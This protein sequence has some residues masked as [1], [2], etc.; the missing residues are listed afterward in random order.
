MSGGGSTIHTAEFLTA[1]AGPKI[2]TP[3]SS[4]TNSHSQSRR[5]EF[6]TIL[7]IPGISGGFFNIVPLGVIAIGSFLV[8]AVTVLKHPFCVDL[9]DYKDKFDGYKRA[10]ARVGTVIVVITIAVSLPLNYIQQTKPTGFM[11]LNSFGPLE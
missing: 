11:I 3:T 7:L 2:P 5:D 1:T 8:W 9:P 4:A 10:A 6:G